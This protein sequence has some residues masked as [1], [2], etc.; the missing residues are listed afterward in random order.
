MTSRPSYGIG[1][2]I[3]QHRAGVETPVMIGDSRPLHKVGSQLGQPVAWNK[4]YCLQ[5]RSQDLKEEEEEGRKKTG[6]KYHGFRQK[7]TGRADTPL[8]YFTTSTFLGITDFEIARMASEEGEVSPRR[9]GGSFQRV[10][11]QDYARPRSEESFALA[12]IHLLSSHTEM[13]DVGRTRARAWNLLGY[14]SPAIQPMPK[15]WWHRA[16]MNSP[17]SQRKYID[18]SVSNLTVPVNVQHEQPVSGSGD[19]RR[20]QVEPSDIHVPESSTS[21]QWGWRGGG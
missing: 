1:I 6:Q 5:G 15:S 11:S 19:S 16:R 20:V 13:R 21:E 12:K 8:V 7:T 9:D 17:T 2:G 4:E 3:A 18:C 14:C 10:E